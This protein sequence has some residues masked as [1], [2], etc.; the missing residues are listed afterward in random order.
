[1]VEQL[2]GLVVQWLFELAKSNLTSTGYKL[3]Q[4]TLNAIM[5]HS[6]AIHTAL[7]KYNQLALLQHLPH[8]T[9]KY[10]EVASYGW[11]GEFE[12][13]KHSHHDLL[14]KP[15]A[16]KANREVASKHF[17]VVRAH[18]EITCLNIKIVWL[19]AWIDQ[20]DAHLLSVATSLL[21]SN[22]L[23]SREV[24]YQY[25][26]CHQVNKV[27]CARLQVIY[28]LPGYSGSIHA[29]DESS[30]VL[31]LGDLDSSLTIFVD[32]DDTLCDEANHLETCMAD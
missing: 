28:D 29:V 21:T 9:L 25:E 13:L 8:L 16:L 15:W 11:L 12:L 27:Y 17:K 19:H 14:S 5:R 32:E 4:H 10:S 23:L 1:V 20:E 3:C 30:I 6:S 26:E 2:E 31:G 22:P 18:E 7:D 24:Q